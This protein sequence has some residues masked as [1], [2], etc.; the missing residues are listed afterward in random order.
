MYS[1]SCGADHDI[2]AKILL[3][4]QTTS[5]ACLA[6]TSSSTRNPNGWLPAVTLLTAWKQ[7]SL[8]QAPSIIAAAVTPMAVPPQTATASWRILSFGKTLARSHEDFKSSG[9]GRGSCER[10]TAASTRPTKASVVNSTPGVGWIDRRGS[11]DGQRTTVPHVTTA[12]YVSCSRRHE[13]E[14]RISLNGRRLPR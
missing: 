3:Y 4:H 12:V 7:P 11:G 8:R 5:F 2:L 14:T 1:S 6:A 9:T 10:L 13:S